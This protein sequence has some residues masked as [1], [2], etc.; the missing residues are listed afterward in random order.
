MKKRK[1]KIIDLF[2]ATLSPILDQL[3]PLHNFSVESQIQ[4][5]APLAFDLQRYDGYS[6]VDREQLS[7]F[8]NSEEWSLGTSLTASVVSMTI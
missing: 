7:V 8:V 4:L 1:W 5:Q 2:T 6:L 3:R